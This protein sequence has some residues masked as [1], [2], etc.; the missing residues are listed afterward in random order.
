MTGPQEETYEAVSAANLAGYWFRARSNGERVV[1]V[2]LWRDNNLV[3]RVW[4]K[5]KSSN[6]D[7][8]E[9]RLRHI[10]SDLKPGI[11][12]PQPKLGDFS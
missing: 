10:R 4:R 12:Q 8:H 11:S 2:N 6:D 3:R 5:G 7:A 1:L 9:Y